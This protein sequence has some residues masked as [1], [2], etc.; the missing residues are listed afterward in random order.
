MAVIRRLGSWPFIVSCCVI[1]LT[2][3]VRAKQVLE[4]QGVNF[5]LAITSYK[6]V[7]VLFYDDS[8]R[9]ASLH[10]AWM[11][12]SEALDDLDADSEL[13]TVSL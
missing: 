10:N 7:A 13:A 2:T 4:L 6:Y 3:I 9:G 11:K 5:E 12:A 1:L 8:A